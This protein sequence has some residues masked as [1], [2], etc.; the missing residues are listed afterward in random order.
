[1]TKRIPLTQ[2]KFA[3]VD[4][5]DFE[6]VNQ[7]KWCAHRIGNTWYATRSK[8]SK[9]ERW[10][11]LMHRFILGVTD[12]K[13]KVDH[14]D[15]DG[16]NNCRHNLREAT[17]AE[18]MHNSRRRVNNTTGYKGVY[19]NRRTGRYFAKLTVNRKQISSD[20]HK[21]PEDAAR[22]YDKLAKKHHGEYAWLNFPD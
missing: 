5:A 13:V 20:G 8:K 14:R 22:A 9:G 17:H 12:R 1:M 16:L 21:T 18:N 19:L 4:D 10:L 3:L 15:R 11:V 7:F 6:R 2:G